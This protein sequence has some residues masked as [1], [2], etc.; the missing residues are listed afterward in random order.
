[1]TAAPN[2][3]ARCWCTW[4]PGD[5][6][7]EPAKANGH[8]PDQTSLGQLDHRLQRLVAISG[9][10]GP[11]CSKELAQVGVEPLPVDDEPEVPA[12][13]LQLDEEVTSARQAFDAAD[14]LLTLAFLNARQAS[15]THRDAGHPDVKAA[16][17]ALE[18]AQE[19]RDRAGDVLRTAKVA[20]REALQAHL[21]RRQREK[22]D[23]SAAARA[24]EPRPVPDRKRQQ[25]APVL[26]RL[27]DKMTAGR[28]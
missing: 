2:G 10:L 23:Q 11:W 17:A 20:Y 19:D 5:P 6:E 18:V 28:N 12:E 16:R 21:A 15:E 26:E 4:L 13:I 22:D 27:R 3:S 14:E 1:M 24:D 25:A 9:H 8:L 7:P